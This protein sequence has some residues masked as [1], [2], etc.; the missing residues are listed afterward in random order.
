M[1]APEVNSGE[2][3]DEVDTTKFNNIDKHYINMAASFVL[4]RYT[5]V[6]ITSFTVLSQIPI[7][8]NNTNPQNT[9]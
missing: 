9:S 4:L 6:T 7:D 8:S 5:S 2:D 3:R 1:H